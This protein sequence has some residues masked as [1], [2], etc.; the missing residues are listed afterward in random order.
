MKIVSLRGRLIGW[1][2]LLLAILLTGFG[3]TA[4]QWIRR[5]RLA[6]IDEE[7]SQRTAALASDLRSPFLRFARNL[8]GRSGGPTGAMPP[9]GEWFFPAGNATP[10]EAPVEE[11][12]KSTEAGASRPFRLS[13]L[14]EHLFE[15]SEGGSRYYYAIW[16]STSGELWQKSSAAPDGLSRPPT[17]RGENQPIITTRAGLR[18]CAWLTD[19]GEL[20]LA[21]VSLDAYRQD[22][23]RFAWWLGGAGL[24]VLVLGMGGAWMVAGRAM[25]PIREIGT[26]A[27]R[28]SAGNLAE[29]ITVA[30]PADELEQLGE[31]LNGTF[32]RLESAFAE[33]RQFTDDA[34]HEIRTP[35]AVIITE[36]QAA[37][38]RPRSPE[39]YQAALA[40][41][42][43]AAQDM[44]R[45][46]E[47]L[48]SL[49]RLDA[50]ESLAAG[51]GTDIA[52]VVSS[53]VALVRP[54]AEAR[55]LQLAVTLEPATLAISP[56]RLRQVAVNLLAN[57]IHYN[58]EGGT[59]RVTTRREGAAV[60]LVVAD[61]GRGIAA[62]H[63]PHIFQR[64]YRAD[65]ARTQTGN[66]FGL[67]LAIV[68]A[69]VDAQGGQV[70]VAS[71][72]GLGTTFTVRFPA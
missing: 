56:S 31:I 54:L 15:Q 5:D 59:V 29:R 20:V 48:L 46:T 25:R 17:P 58:Y 1:I 6:R 70:S 68:K 39:E 64:F 66:R 36:A 55:R 71:E 10:R 24:G 37:L 52:E 65:P 72:L 16:W 35:L 3:L 34:S 8:A 43:E 42:L 27:R 9:P 4:Y 41:C 26:A 14:T 13:R 30:N 61:T 44:R 63:L 18:E 50:G 2:A 62:E 57:A 60:V 40:T 38:A 28:I 19:R 12:G 49:S 7:L 23:R 32:A 51:A 22:L 21:G 53:C 11:P 47:S 69:I 33:Q 67:G 45:L